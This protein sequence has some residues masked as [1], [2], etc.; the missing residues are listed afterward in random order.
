[1]LGAPGEQTGEGENKVKRLVMSACALTL[2]A[3]GL[4]ANAF[5]KELRVGTCAKGGYATI[6][7][8]VNAA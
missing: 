8:A 3:L 7:A 4:T 6:Q 1:V 5:A 2:I